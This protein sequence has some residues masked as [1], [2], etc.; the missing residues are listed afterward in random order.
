MLQKYSEAV[1]EGG[2]NDPAQLKGN[3]DGPGPAKTDAYGE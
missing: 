1:D 3:R 2:Q